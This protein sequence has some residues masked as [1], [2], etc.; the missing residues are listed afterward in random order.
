MILKLSYFII[1]NILGDAWIS[2]ML[3]NIYVWFLPCTLLHKWTTILCPSSVCRSGYK[4]PKCLKI[5]TLISQ[6]LFRIDVW[7]IF[8][9]ILL[10]KELLLFEYFLRWVGYNRYKKRNSNISA[11]I[12]DRHVFCEDSLTPRH[13][14]RWITPNY[15]QTSAS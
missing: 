10:I 4:R 1:T 9:K 12:S 14:I 8:V 6:L 15:L 11:A 3:I 13:L 5:E 7:F 2:R